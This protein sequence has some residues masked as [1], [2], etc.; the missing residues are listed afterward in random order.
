MSAPLNPPENAPGAVPWNDPARAGRFAG[1]LARIAPAHSLAP[2]TLSIA[3]A[4]ASFRR[5]LRIADTRRHTFIIMDAPPDKEDC[6]PFVKVAQLMHEA[7]LNA[8][9]VLEWDEADGFM[10]ITDL[11][12]RTMI[13][14]VDRDRPEAN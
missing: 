10:L 3:S 2:Q 8:P 13:E 9:R 7:G 12:T 5:Y 14:A 6:R 1:W 4:D 11:G